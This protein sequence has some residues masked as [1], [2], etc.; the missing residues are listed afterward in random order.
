MPGSTR[1]G[2]REIPR[3]PVPKGRA[4]RFIALLHH[5]YNVARWRAAYAAL[6]PRAAAGLDGKTWAHYGQDLEANRR[7]LP[8]RLQRGASRAQAVRR[9]YIPKADGS[10]RGLGLPALEDKLAQRA[11]VEVLDAIADT[12]FL[13]FSYGFRPGRSPHDALDALSTGLLTKKG[14]WVMETEPH[15]ERKVLIPSEC[16]S[17]FCSGSVWRGVLSQGAVGGS[18]SPQANGGAGRRDRTA[19]AG[20]ISDAG[21]DRYDESRFPARAPSLLEARR[22]KGAWFE[23]NTGGF[24]ARMALMAGS[25][26]NSSATKARTTSRF[27]PL[28]WANSR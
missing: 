9:A 18:L 4:K 28:G 17:G 8:G 23:V 16:L 21:S 19:A 1:H 11:V 26:S 7:D 3:P 6:N 25:A 27:Q 24:L 10:A 2:N 13:G 22:K 12:D 14:N 15:S 5:V 20:P